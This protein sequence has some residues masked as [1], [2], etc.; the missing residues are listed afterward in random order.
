MAT[1]MD[2]Y[3][4]QAAKVSGRKFFHSR[5]MSWLYQNR[6]YDA[7][8]HKNSMV[9]QGFDGEVDSIWLWG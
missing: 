6:G 8:I 1:G 9:R 4:M 5:C 3:N 2:T 7:R